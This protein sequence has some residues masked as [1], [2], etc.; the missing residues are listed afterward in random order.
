MLRPIDP[1]Y[2]LDLDIEDPHLASARGERG[3]RLR[4]VVVGDGEEGKE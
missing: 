1:N 4:W 3:E 2:N